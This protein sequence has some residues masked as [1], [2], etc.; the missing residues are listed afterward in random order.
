MAKV[1]YVI[2]NVYLSKC[3][4]PVTYSYLIF[5][6]TFYNFVKLLLYTIT[7][8]CQALLLTNTLAC[9]I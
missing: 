2:D 9:C 4:L 7:H 3:L 1:R 6:E 5:I 8:V